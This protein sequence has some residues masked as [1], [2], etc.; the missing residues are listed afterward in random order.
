MRKTQHHGRGRTAS[1]TLVELMMVIVVISVLAGITVSVSKYASWRA[2]QAQKEIVMEKIRAALEEYKALNGEYPIIG[3]LKHYPRIHKTED[4]AQGLSPW[5]NVALV[6]NTIE[7]LGPDRLDYSLVYPLFYGPNTR[8]RK[9]FMT[10][11][12]VVVCDLTYKLDADTPPIK[13]DMADGSARYY[14]PLNSII[15]RKAIDPATGR[16]LGYVCSNGLSYYFVTNA[17]Q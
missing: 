5:T 6:T 4:A 17:F 7:V 15:R 8:K 16:Q 13:L 14:W 1:F 9:P 10:F 12:A 2:T 3:D 11:P